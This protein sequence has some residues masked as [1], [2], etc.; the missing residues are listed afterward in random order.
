MKKNIIVFLLFQ[1]LLLLSTVYSQDIKNKIGIGFHGG[2]LTIRGNR[3]IDSKLD[4][5]GFKSGFT[6]S[7]KFN[8]YLTIQLESGYARSINHTEII[9]LEGEGTSKK[10]EINFKEFPIIETS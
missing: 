5:P 3:N 2:I 7:Y 10:T 4:S 6:F 9:P 1:N 8:N